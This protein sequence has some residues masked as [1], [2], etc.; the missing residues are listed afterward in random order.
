MK[1]DNE[2]FICDECGAEIPVIDIY[3]NEASI[4]LIY[5]DSHLTEETYET[6]CKQCKE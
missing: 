6:L 1:N 5:P 3:N 2:T 4:K